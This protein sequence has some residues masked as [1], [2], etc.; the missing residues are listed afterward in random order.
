MFK[1][2]LTMLA[3]ILTL[4]GAMTL[5]SCSDDDNKS[6]NNSSSNPDIER[7][8]MEEWEPC[9]K[10]T[11]ISGI[12]NEDPDLQAV[13]RERFPNQTT[14]L[15]NA[16][17]AFVS[18]TVAKANAKAMN[19][20]YNRGG[21][22][23]MMRPSME[24]FEAMDDL[25]DDDEYEDEEGYWD[26]DINDNLF[27]SE[28]EEMDEIFYAF[29]KFDE[30]YTMFEE[31]PFDGNYEEED[32][33]LSEE[34]EEAIRA[35]H[36]EHPD[37]TDNDEQEWLYDNDAE[38]NENYFQARMDPF[39][40]FIEELDQ[41]TRHMSTRASDDTESLKVSPDDGFYFVKNIPISLN[42]KIEGYYWNKS[43]SITLKLYV[44]PAYMFS[45]N[46]SDKAGD[47]Y[48][49]KSE[50][51]PHLRPLWEVASMRGGL[52]NWGRCRIYAYWFDHMYSE[53][54]LV[55]ISDSNM[56]HSIEDYVEFYK[57]PIPDADNTEV[58]YSK[59][60]NWGLNGSV[61][62]EGK[63]PKPSLGFSVEWSTERS[64]AIK[65][66]QYERNT[67]TS[68]CKYRFWA[69]TVVL[70]DADYENEQAT[71]DNFPSITHTEFTLNTAWLW[72]VPANNSL[73]VADNEN[74]QFG[75]R[76]KINPGFASWYHWRATAEFNSNKE[77]Y[78]GYVG[79]VSGWFEFC[80]K[81]PAPNRTPFGIVALKNAAS[82][83]T[84]GNIKIYK[85]AEFAEQ[86]VNA[87]VFA[88]IPSSY[89]VN[90]VAKKKLPEGTYALT[91]QAIDPNQDNKVLG[92]WKYE[93]IEIEQ[94]ESA[95]EATTEISTIN[96]VKIQ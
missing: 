6:N 23:V 39:I 77:L 17:V 36:E 4:C 94:G 59:G 71:N 56:V 64:Y 68:V 54:D 91:F 79:N 38:Q 58:T 18:F 8:K 5:T 29:N 80:E 47:Y 69:P 10:L 45:S 31:K 76:V 22:V 27:F 53:Y 95:E 49:V 72:R 81:L 20:F 16:E 37:E 12:E 66:I 15:S 7:Q 65:S 40:D 74:T 75:L 43:S 21:L 42:H 13:I 26:D 84:V 25:L 86:G 83:Y 82:S 44:T 1:K 90:K 52:F 89:N 57:H 63:T 55:D 11:Y 96:A 78:N 14:D 30:Y 51:I 93:N 2:T 32:T 33:E 92:N 67:T 61:E 48:L 60:F 41:S 87:P 88:T 85:Q 70:K 35:Y 62:V 9:N 73:K 46:G 34:I 50:I 24:D 28:S 19:D 3:A